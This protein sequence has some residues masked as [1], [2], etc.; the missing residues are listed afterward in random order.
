MYV[1][2]CTYGTHQT[3]WTKR[4]A[5]WGIESDCEEYHGTVIKELIEEC[6]SQAEQVSRI[7]SATA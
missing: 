3:A 1:I 4:A 6:T 2:K 7:M 5:L